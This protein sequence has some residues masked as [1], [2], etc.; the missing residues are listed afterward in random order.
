MGNRDYLLDWTENLQAMGRYSFTFEEA[1]RQF[2]ENSGSAITQSLYGLVTRGKILSVFKGFYIIITPE[3]S[4]KGIIPPTMFIDALMKYAGKNYYVGLLSA[5][6]YHGA[7][8]QRPQEYFVVHDLPAIRPTE[9]RGIRINYIGRIAINQVLLEKQK[10]EAGY[11]QVSSPE[12]TA[13]DMLQYAKYIGGV[14]R[15]AT[16]ISELCEKIRPAKISPELINGTQAAVLQ[17]LGFIIENVV[18]NQRLGDEIYRKIKK[19]IPK[20][21]PRLLKASGT[22]T[23]F[24]TDPKWKIIINTEIEIDE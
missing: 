18:G 19:V 13:V 4:V 8:H 6:V 15:A 21:R 7:A 17:R 16:V 23:G 5:A 12:L 11:I 20:F 10:T 9:K 3:Y 24:E 1:C 14:N 22:A 2:P